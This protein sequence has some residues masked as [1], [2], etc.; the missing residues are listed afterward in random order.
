MKGVRELLTL[1]E[2]ESGCYDTDTGGRLEI[3]TFLSAPPIL[4]L[5]IVISETGYSVFKFPSAKNFE[6]G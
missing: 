1:C 2:E 4:L 3:G 6:S 5:K